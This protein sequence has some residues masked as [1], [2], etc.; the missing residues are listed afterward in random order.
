M[1]T[2]WF[3]SLKVLAEVRVRRKTEQ[4]PNSLRDVERATLAEVHL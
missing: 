4:L 2:G 1:K 3:D